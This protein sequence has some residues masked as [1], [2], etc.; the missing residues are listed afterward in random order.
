MPIFAGLIQAIFQALAA[1]MLRLLAA[2][3]ALRVAAV[4]AVMGFGAALMVTFNAF[5]APLA[6]SVFSTAYGQLL[7]LAF[8]PISGTVLAGM[9]ALWVACTTYKL[10]VRAVGMV[11]NV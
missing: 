11:A 6:A 8:P 1:F 2:R 7:G 3:I 9:V 5:V 10:Q 4:L